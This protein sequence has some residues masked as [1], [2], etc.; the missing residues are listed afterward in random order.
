MRHKKTLNQ[1]LR[2]VKRTTSEIIWLYGIHPVKAALSN[3]KR[4]I[5]SLLITENTIKKLNMDSIPSK[6]NN[7]INIVN[8][9][10]IDSIVGEDRV[11]QG[12]ILK[13]KVRENAHLDDIIKIC[14]SKKYSNI[15]I[16]DNITDP[17]NVG[18]IIRSAYAF[19]VTAIILSKNGAPQEN[20]TMA[21]SASGALE[22]I[23]IV[24]VT[25]LTRSINI[26]KKNG[27]WSLGLESQAKKDISEEELP[28]KC[29]IIMG[30]EGRGIRKLVRENCDTFI[31]L[32]T[33][34]R[35]ESLNV[36]TAASIALYEWQRQIKKKLIV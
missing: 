9:S 36:S 27:F 32:P 19:G 30:S 28:N 33:N 34:E 7:L 14:S 21:K 26:L 23:P 35:L 20:G 11:H 8:K 4:E 15:V 17:H 12:I 5:K 16:L 6:I 24:R 1:D 18:A 2:K 13:T 22:L 3:P 29:L 25:N 10:E 31:R